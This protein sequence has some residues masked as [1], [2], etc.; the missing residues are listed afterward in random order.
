MNQKKEILFLNP[1]RYA[2]RLYPQLTDLGYQV[3]IG[4]FEELIYSHDGI[5]CRGKN[6]RD[7]SKII[8]GSS[9][10][11]IQNVYKKY[12][13]LIAGI[14]EY[15]A[16]S[17]T[18]I[19]S[20]GANLLVGNKLYQLEL[21]RKRK[22]PL[23]SQYS[24]YTIEQA[25]SIWFDSLLEK[26]LIIKELNK[27][28][29]RGIHKVESYFE[30]RKIFFE[31]ST[32][33]SMPLL[34][35]AFIDNDGDYR[36]LIIQNRI[37]GI[38]KRTQTNP[39]EYRNNFSQGASGS[40]GYLPEHVLHECLELY[41]DSGLLIAGIDV[42]QNKKTGEYHFLEINSNPGIEGFE[43]TTGIDV[44]KILIDIIEKLV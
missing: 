35:Q 5:L 6:L 8:I 13:A 17:D 33:D 16:T 32:L 40:I 24:A 28:Q 34:L 41:K 3:T 4:M 10:S 29:G 14:T 27:N 43:K 19:I 11:V 42:I 39:E 36:V 12:G 25:N 23:I 44:G 15:C 22:L 9:G 1:R 7:F 37:I 38:M 30:L 20:L 2:D 18:K 31:H 26:P 21:I